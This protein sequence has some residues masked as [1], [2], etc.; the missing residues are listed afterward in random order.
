MLEGRC[1]VGCH[2][3]FASFAHGTKGSAVISTSGHSPARCRIYK[4]QK[5]GNKADLTRAFPQPEPSP[6]QLEWDYLIQAIRGDTPYNE[7]ERGVM[8]SL[9]TSM[10]RMACHTGQV[11]TL[12]EMENCPH[13]FAPTVDQLTMNSPAPLQANPDGKYPVPSPASSATA[14]IE[15]SARATE[16]S[17]VRCSPGSNTRPARLGWGNEPAVH[18]SQ[19]QQMEEDPESPGPF[20]SPFARN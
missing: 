2:Q 17:A 7:V 8:A 12:D 14:S 9:V 19:E 4:T 10:G 6:Y 11:V 16:G 1:M 5:I 18:V 20:L 13:E 15:R 3:E